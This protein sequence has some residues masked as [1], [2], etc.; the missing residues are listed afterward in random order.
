MAKKKFHPEGEGK[1]RDLTKP[2]S[3][4]PVDTYGGRV[5]IK[6]DQSG[7]LTPNGQL[8][9]FIE[10]LKTGGVFD[11]WVKIC[12]M[13]F[14]SPNASIAR[15]VL[16]TILLSV[17]CGHTRYSHIS[18]IRN[19]PVNAA[20][21]GMTKV[22]SED[23]VRRSL[24]DNLSEQ[25][26]NYWLRKTLLDTYLPILGENWI[27]DVD[28]TIKTLYGKQEGSVVGYNHHKPGRPSHTYHSYMIANLRLIL[29]VDVHAGNEHASKHTA[30]GIWSLLSHLPRSCWPTFIRGD[31]G[32]GTNQIMTECENLKLPYLFK[33]KKTKLVKDLVRHH[34]NKTNW[35]YVGHGWEGIES[36]LSLTGWEQKRR[37]VVLRRPLKKEVL[38][39]RKNED[40]RQMALDFGEF[41]SFSK[42]YEY[43]VLITSLEDDI[44][45]VTQHYRDRA[46]CENNFDELK[47]HWGWCGFTTQDLKRTRFMSKI[48]AL[49]YNW[50]TLFIR[51]ITPH[52]HTEAITSRPLMLN[53]AGRQTK[54]ANQTQITICNTHAKAKTIYKKLVKISSFMKWISRTAEQLTSIDRWCLIL[55]RALVKYLKGRVLKPPDLVLE[56][57]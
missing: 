6:W 57:G 1:K 16:G 50:W 26:G 55:S 47:N 13:K 33:L 40:T 28:T 23:A 38:L 21:L 4:I 54:H 39:S 35:L 7:S 43:A 11:R 25:A 19:D 27:L 5:Y 29:D 18:G 51:L 34:M 8:P 3:L 12:P 17:L 41:E 31:C 53:A 10:F 49:I 46:D 42:A 24:R 15:D 44:G 14:T 37:V 20:L 32:F 56:S 2:T 36:K 22:V 48:I 9:F 45:I 52:K 30:P